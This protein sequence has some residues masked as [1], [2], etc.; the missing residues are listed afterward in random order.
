M[1][2]G[3]KRRGWEMRKKCAGILISLCCT[4]FL[5]PLTGSAKETAALEGAIG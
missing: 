4:L 1:G 5:L 2:E 3:R